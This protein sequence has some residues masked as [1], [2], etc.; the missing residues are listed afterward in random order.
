MEFK[1]VIGRREGMIQTPAPLP[2]RRE[3]VK[4]LARRFGLPE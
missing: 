2:N 3:E 1:E 4:E